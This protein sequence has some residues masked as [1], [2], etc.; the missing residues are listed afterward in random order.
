MTRKNANQM[1]VEEFSNQSDEDILDT[2]VEE[3]FGQEPEPTAD[4]KSENFDYLASDPGFREEPT[5]ESE[6]PYD[7]MKDLDIDFY[8]ALVILSRCPGVIY[9]VAQAGNCTFTTDR[10]LMHVY[11]LELPMS[12]AEIA[13]RLGKLVR[14]GQLEKVRRGTYQF[15]EFSQQSYSAIKAELDAMRDARLNPT[16]R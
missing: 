16:K 5:V 7:V 9:E 14:Q 3:I 15:P 13:K 2:P 6:E 11:R 8:N 4:D 1:T 10:V 12:D